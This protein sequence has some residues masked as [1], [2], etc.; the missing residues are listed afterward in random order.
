MLAH[1]QHGGHEP[2]VVVSPSRTVN[3]YFIASAHDKPDD[4][5]T[6]VCATRYA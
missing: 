1:L 3:G 4:V 2:E 6:T 5:L